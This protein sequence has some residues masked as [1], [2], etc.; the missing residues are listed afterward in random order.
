MIFGGERLCPQLRLCSIL[1]SLLLI[2]VYSI[3]VEAQW[4]Y[5]LS[6]NK[7]LKLQSSSSG[8]SYV[9]E[10]IFALGLLAGLIWLAVRGARSKAESI[11]EM[12]ESWMGFHYSDLVFQWGPPDYVFDDGFGGRIIYYITS[13][14]W[15]VPGR[16]E[17]RTVASATA[18]DSMIWGSA[19]QTTTYTPPQV[20]G[21]DA[22]RAFRINE[23][24]Y[25]FDY[26]WKGL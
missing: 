19:R 1:I 13:R 5:S 8:G 22:I 17:T 23:N 21:Y 24:G 25:I 11:T 6:K 14:T 9:L 16:A 12:M 18:Y 4:D 2:L 10:G 15:V 26:M 3:P 7:D 20:Q